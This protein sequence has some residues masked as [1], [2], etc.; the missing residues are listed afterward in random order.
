MKMDDQSHCLDLG[1]GRIRQNH[2]AQQSEVEMNKRNIFTLAIITI[3][4]IIVGVLF[5]YLQNPTTG[6]NLP[7]IPSNS[8]NSDKSAEIQKA[9]Q[10]LNDGNYEGAYQAYTV[11][12]ESGQDL[13]VAYAGRGDILSLWRRFLEASSDYTKSIEHEPNAVVLTSRCNTY[14]LLAKFDL[15]LQ[16]CQDAIEFDPEYLDGRHALATLYMEQGDLDNAQTTIEEAL[17]INPESDFAHFILG[18]VLLNS[19]KVDEA[20]EEY[21][22]AI[23]LNP[24]EPQ[25]YWER[26]FVYYATAQLQLAKDDLQKVI[27]HGD[28]YKHSSLIYQAGSLMNSIG[29]I[30]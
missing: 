21:S 5:V 12:I 14:R 24:T 10:L 9:E 28:P 4:I 26:G 16:D 6:I 2:C 17:K 27:D 19:G 15:A 3:I 11:A 8:E 13:A 22:I 7:F 1:N 30:P 18:T 25:Y 29:S 23:Q 20:I